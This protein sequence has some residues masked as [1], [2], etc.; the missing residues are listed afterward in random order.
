MKQLAATLLIVGVLVAWFWWIAAAIAVIILWKLA[1][2]AIH[3][4]HTTAL[5]ARA[6]REVLAARATEEHAL[7]LAGDPR[8]V[9]GQYEPA[10]T[11]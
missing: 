2:H 7:V 1:A 3:T 4:H 10:A 9:Y 6:Q 5:E 8:G 11:A